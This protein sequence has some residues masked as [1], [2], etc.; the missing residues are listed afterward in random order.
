MR[1]GET[2]DNRNGIVQGQRDTCLNELGVQQAE[3]TGRY[4]R[5][6]GVKFDQIWASD[7][8]RAHGTAEIIA[9]E[10][11]QSVKPIPDKRLR[12]RCLG[13]LEG[14]RRGCG[15]TG[16]GSESPKA[17]VDR[18]LDFW[19]AEINGQIEGRI[20][21]VSHGAALRAWL[22]AGLIENL[23]FSVKEMDPGRRLGNCSLTEVEVNADGGGTVLSFARSEHLKGL[24]AGAQA[25]ADEAA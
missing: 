20:L 7:L 23:G 9:A 14:K 6:H 21:I 5:S 11:D 13:D 18:F 4:F 10:S 17:V 25:N 12:E 19:R 3:W 16:V 1:H 2:D 8:E 22:N 24:A 15:A